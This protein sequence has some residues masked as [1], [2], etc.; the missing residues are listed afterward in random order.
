MRSVLAHPE[1]WQLYKPAQPAPAAFASVTLCAMNLLHP[2]KLLLSKWTAVRPVAREKHFLVSKVILPETPDSKVEW[3]ELEAV[4]SKAVRRM[5]W[6]EL[7]D[8]TQWRQGWV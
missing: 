8:G 7:C 2:K 4:H 6:R 3:V 5:A 1:R